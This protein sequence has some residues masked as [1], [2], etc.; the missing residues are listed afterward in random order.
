M[1]Y[2]TRVS[3][4]TTNNKNVILIADQPWQTLVMK[5]ISKKLKQFRPELNS[6]IVTSDYFT[7]LHGKGIIDNLA[8]D[9]SITIETQEAIYWNWQGTETIDLVDIRRFL[10]GWE[11]QN[12]VTRSLESIEQTNQWVYGNERSFFYL[13]LNEYWKKRILMDS[14]IFA[15]EI[16]SN[17]APLLVISIERS[18]LLT[19]LMHARAESLSIPFY[20]FIPSRIQHLWL[21]RE[22][23]GRG[24]SLKML[25]QMEELS[26]PEIDKGSNFINLLVNTKR[27]IYSSIENELRDSYSARQENPFRAF[28]Q[29]QRKFAGRVYDRI[30]RQRNIYRNRI[31]RLEQ[32]LVK[33]SLLEFK[34]SILFLLHSLGFYKCGVTS[35]PND[36]YFLWALHARPEG[37]VLVLGNGQD[38]IAA[39]RGVSSKIPRGKSLVVKE[40][41]EM[42]GLRRPGFYRELQALDSVILADP[43]SETWKFLE[44]CIGVIGMSGTI[45][46]EGEFIGKRSLALGTPEF[47]GV[48]SYVG[49]EQLNDF[50]ESAKSNPNSRPSEK[51]IK[52]VAQILRET[53]G[54]PLP[55]DDQDKTSQDLEQLISSVTSQRGIGEFVRAIIDVLDSP[56]KVRN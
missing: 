53:K 14:I 24:T 6:I 37:S 9:P 30:F 33:L 10:E 18:T 21:L 34:K 43:F 20:S 7:F 13:P 55:T 3:V 41:P 12:C 52:Y 15:E 29:D 26:Q 50:F 16:F 11:N 32:D 48:I 35:P 45:L 49:T 38:E 1:S 36:E 25:Q 4:S 17:Y 23:L 44:N 19:N 40:N 47:A 8:S 31:F 46:L 27:G 54:I 51:I 56:I 2:D 22:N 42:F 39:L 5:E 28:F